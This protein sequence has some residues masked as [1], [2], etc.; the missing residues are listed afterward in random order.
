M[1]Q[2]VM[3][4]EDSYGVSLKAGVHTFYP[5]LIAVAIS[6]MPYRPHLV[7]PGVFNGVTLIRYRAVV[8]FDQ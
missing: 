5:H 2:R 4:G 6:L 7:P 1:N 3:F 8:E